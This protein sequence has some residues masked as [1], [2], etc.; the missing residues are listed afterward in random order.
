MGL[1]DG[2]RHAISYDPH[3]VANLTRFQDTRFGS[4]GWQE[5]VW[6]ERHGLL[7]T[8]RTLRLVG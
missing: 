4:S 8:F 5:S 7:M 3:P 1:T 6:W 2:C